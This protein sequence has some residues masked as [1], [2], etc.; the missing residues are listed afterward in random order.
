EVDPHRVGVALSTYFIGLDL[1]LGEGPY[2]LGSLHGLFDYSQIYILCGL[3]PVVVL[4]LYK[5]FYKTKRAVAAVGT[6]N[7]PINEED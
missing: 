1:G 7:Q 5:L 2:A 3:I 6:M 4:V